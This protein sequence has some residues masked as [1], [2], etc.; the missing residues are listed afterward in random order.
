MTKI[1]RL[2]SRYDPDN[3]DQEFIDLEFARLDHEEEIQ[4]VL[5]KEELTEVILNES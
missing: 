2:I 5:I 1:L 3:I 4:R